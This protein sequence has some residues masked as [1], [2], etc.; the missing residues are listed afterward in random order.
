MSV[1]R[2][3]KRRAKAAVA[4]VALLC[5]AAYFFWQATQGAHGL[6]EFAKRQQELVAAKAELARTQAAQLAWERRVIA[7][8]S[9]R[10]DPDALDE[11]ARAMLNLSRP[12]DIIVPYKPTDR[13]F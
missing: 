10:L 7:L 5:L 4:P 9:D 13:L 2:A 1:A 8:R 6:D 12:D 11:R 3:M